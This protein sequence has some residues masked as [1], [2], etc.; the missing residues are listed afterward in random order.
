MNIILTYINRLHPVEKMVLSGMS[1]F[2][3]ITL[4][5]TGMYIKF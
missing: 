3:A 1:L 4:I 5:Y 2:V